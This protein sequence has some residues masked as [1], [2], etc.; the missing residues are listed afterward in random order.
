MFVVTS[1]VRNRVKLLLNGMGALCGGVI[2][3][4][5]S[6]HAIENPRILTEQGMAYFRSGDVQ[7]SVTAF[8]KAI[9]VNPEIQ[10]YL[11]QRGLSLYYN[12]QYDE[13][14]NQ[15]KLDVKKNPKDTE[16]AVWA[17]L[18]DVNKEN[19]LSGTSRKQSNI[20]KLSGTDPRPVMKAVYDLYDGSL[21]FNS[22]QNILQQATTRGDTSTSTIFYLNL[23]LSLYTD[24]MLRDLQASEKYINNALA[25]DYTKNSGDYMISV[26][27]QQ[28]IRLRSK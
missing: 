28:A 11:W 9:D 17:L 20:I 25:A 15:F 18:C 12:N 21:S 26:A 1:T 14:S 10:Q 4:S 27:K 3:Q 5:T 13:C 8:N 19:S 2:I 6:V 22:Y 7:S 16:E 24:V 23:Y